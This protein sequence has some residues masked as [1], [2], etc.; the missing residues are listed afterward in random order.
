MAAVEDIRCSNFRT[1]RSESGS[2]R[3]RARTL[4]LLLT[5]L[6]LLQHEIKIAI[7]DVVRPVPVSFREN[8]LS[9]G[10]HRSSNRVARKDFLIERCTKQFG[11]LVSD[12]PVRAHVVGNSAPH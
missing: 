2:V 1:Y 10:E 4:T 6:C 11:C 9:A 5:R 7:Q 3:I 12:G 8:S